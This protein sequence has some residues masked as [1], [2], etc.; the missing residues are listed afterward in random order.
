M[1]TRFTNHYANLGIQITSH[2]QLS[3]VRLKDIDKAYRRYAKKHHPDK[4][5][6]VVKFEAARVAVEILRDTV[7]RNE[8]DEQFV[9]Y[10]REQSRL[11]AQDAHTK[12]MRTELE[13][14]EKAAAS[15][16]NSSRTEL[17]TARDMGSLVQASRSRRIKTFTF[18]EHLEREARILQ[19]AR[20]A[21]S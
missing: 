13:E 2:E 19:K 5:G 10:L 7:T 20:S 17:F 3:G 11:A 18:E 15:G 4:G 14:R 9:K 1:A 16:E 21:V 6:D 12:R 8:Y